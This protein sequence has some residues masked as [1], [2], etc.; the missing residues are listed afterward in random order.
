M[1]AKNFGEILFCLLL[2]IS[3]ISLSFGYNLKL[4][5]IGEKLEY[6]AKFGFINLGNMVLKIVDTTTIN[7]KQ[8]YFV[9]SHL[10]SSS[11]LNFLFTLND[12]INVTTTINDLVPLFYEK[13]IHEGK[14]SIYQKLFF[15]QDSLY[16]TIND[17]A[18]IKISQPV[19][20]LLSFWYYLRRIPLV[21]NDTIVVYIFEAR[22]QHRIECRVGKKETIKTPLGKFSTIR[23]TPKA[24]N[25]GVFGAGGAMDIWYT[26]DEK[27][28]PVQ[29]KTKLKFGTVLFKLKGVSN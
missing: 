1:N 7:G 26:D 24:P 15:N 22:Q 16:V 4:F 14:Y 3:P 10:N 12:T 8:C 20:D 17:S 5:P 23:V 2:L 29:I 21:E 18:K 25:K 19:M 11:D 27:R 28:F 6:E 9:S 13:R